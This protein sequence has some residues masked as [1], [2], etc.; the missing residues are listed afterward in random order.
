MSTGL[1]GSRVKVYGFVSDP[2][3]KAKSDMRNGCQMSILGWL[4]REKQPFR[5]QS[6]GY[7]PSLLSLFEYT[8][9]ALLSEGKL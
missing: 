3:R 6:S 2:E 1:K 7:V 5:Q 4:R 8:D 9:I